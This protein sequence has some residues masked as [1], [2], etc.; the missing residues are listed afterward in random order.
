MRFVARFFGFLWRVSRGGA[1]GGDVGLRI[2][3]GAAALYTFLW[4]VF[5]VVAIVLVVL[6][7]DL[8]AVDRWLGAHTNW[9]ELIG[10][11]LWR[12]F[13]GLIVL[14]SGLAIYTLGQEMIDPKAA[15]DDEEEGGATRRHK[16][17]VE[18][19]PKRKI[20]S[21]SFGILAFLAVGY[22]AWVGMTMAD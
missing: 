18:K 3:S 21:R 1:L 13:C 7:F 19:V 16:A 20:V 10:D 5:L 8:E 4:L 14:L 6:G 15:E 2:G 9:F 22:L 12:A 17:G 11:I